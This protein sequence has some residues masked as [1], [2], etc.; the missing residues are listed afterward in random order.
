MVSQEPTLPP[1]N[2]GCEVGREKKKY[3]KEQKV[4]SQYGNHWRRRQ[5]RVIRNIFGRDAEER[6]TQRKSL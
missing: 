6:E 3:E 2:G 5:N 4:E 1:E